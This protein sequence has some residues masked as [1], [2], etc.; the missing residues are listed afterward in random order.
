MFEF[1][2]VFRQHSSDCLLP[3]GKV[4]QCMLLS[5]NSLFDHEVFWFRLYLNRKYYI[6]LSI[7]NNFH[8]SWLII[9]FIPAEIYMEYLSFIQNN[10]QWTA[11]FHTFSPLKCTDNIPKVAN[12]FQV[13]YLIN[14][15]KERKKAELTFRILLHTKCP[16]AFIASIW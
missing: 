12:M 13:P 3:N 2:V 11:N 10:C 8:F 4:V 9:V 15:G 16:H 7:Q 6:N 1:D 14:D 5:G